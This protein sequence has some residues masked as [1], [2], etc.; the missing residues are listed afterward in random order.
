[1]VVGWAN[2]NYVE[3]AWGRRIFVILI[4]GFL[5]WGA[6]LLSNSR[7]FCHA[8]V[9]FIYLLAAAGCSRH[10]GEAER[11]RSLKP[12]ACH[13]FSADKLQVVASKV[14]SVPL[15]SSPTEIERVLGRPSYHY[16]L[17]NVQATR[18]YGWV[19]FYVLHCP[20]NVGSFPKDKYIQLVVRSDAGLSAIDYRGLSGLSRRK[21]AEM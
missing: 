12:E 2:D 10:G 5:Q 19:W 15:G 11:L 4:D 9:L 3:V 1:M 20:K 13:E 6:A 21:R 14:D 16:P 17:A 7:I 18:L 8:G